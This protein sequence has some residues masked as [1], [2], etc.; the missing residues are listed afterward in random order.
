ME[1]AHCDRNL[2][3][4]WMIT[5]AI[6]LLNQIHPHTLY[7]PIGVC[8]M[9]KDYLNGSSFLEQRQRATEDYSNQL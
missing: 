1:A 7:K 2:M 9:R 5:R 8:W 3:L 4:L 6:F